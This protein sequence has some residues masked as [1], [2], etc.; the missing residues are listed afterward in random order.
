MSFMQEL[1]AWP[2]ERIEKIIAHATLHDVDRALAREERTARDLAA[3]L[4]P[5]AEAR[6]EEM[7]REANR[8]TRWHFG[9]TVGF[10]VPL[11]ISNVCGADCTYCG[12]SVR[13]GIKE[14]RVT[15]S[16]EEIRREC[17]TLAAHG[18][19]SVLLLTGEA[20]RAVPLDY[21]AEAVTVAREYFP[22]VSVEI[23]SL[24]LEEYGRLC[25]LGLEGVTIYMETYHRPT[26]AQAHL[27]GKKKDYE[28]RLDAVERAG[29]AGARRISIGVLLG[30]F[31][32][33]VDGFWLG[34]HARY[35]QRAC[36]Q[37]AVSI[38]FPRLQHVPQRFK[39]PR[40]VTERDLVQLMLALRLF[41][42]EVG[43]NLS[44][45]EAPDFRDR[46]IPLGVTM[47]SAGSS[48]RPGGYSIYGEGTLEQF[49]LEDH[50]SPEEV[51]QAVRKAGYDPVWKDYDRAFDQ[52]VTSDE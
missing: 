6:L 48:T 4:S 1:A 37:S 41:L 2:Q 12:Y 38:S 15:L 25:C 28:H 42:P 23:Y 45:R 18:F 10:Y 3:L 31:D 46:L 14:R 21:I 8:L 19:Q 47:M 27:I 52:A 43:F 7:A 39:I 13:S 22:S 26:Y 17:E 11:Y 49:A 36:W 29:K 50:R 30:L 33:R 9:R 32:W 20:P 24:D 5:H 34:L 16:L 44:T 35:L 40:F 51:A